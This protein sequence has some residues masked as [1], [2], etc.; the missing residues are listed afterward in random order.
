MKVSGKKL[1]ANKGADAI[2]IY[3][4]AKDGMLFVDEAYSLKSSPATT[5]VLV[6]AIRKEGGTMVVVA[7]YLEEMREWMDSNQGL[8]NRFATEVL[9]CNYKAEKSP[10][11]SPTPVRVSSLSTKPS[12]HKSPTS[13]SA[14]C[15]SSVLPTPAET[16]I[17]TRNFSPPRHPI[18]CHALLRTKKLLSR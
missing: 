5:T 6:N 18:H 2:T 9:I 17:P 3:K 13:T 10:I 7:G 14:G 1:Q 4:S 8:P 15:K 12:T 11:Y 16:M